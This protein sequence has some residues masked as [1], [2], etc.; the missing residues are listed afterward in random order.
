[1]ELG[2]LTDTG[3]AGRSVKVSDLGGLV[4][5]PDQGVFSTPGSDHQDAH[6]GEFRLPADR[7]RRELR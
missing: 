7:V 3:V 1:M 6:A 2:P 4:E 5:L